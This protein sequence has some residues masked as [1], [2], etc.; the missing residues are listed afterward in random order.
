MLTLIMNVYVLVETWHLLTLYANFGNKDLC[1]K[2]VVD[3]I[4]VILNQLT[5]TIPFCINGIWLQS[6]ANFLC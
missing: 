3:G 4:Y 6:L 2:N 5:I 1:L